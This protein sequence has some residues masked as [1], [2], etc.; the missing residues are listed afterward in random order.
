MKT[1]LSYRKHAVPSTEQSPLELEAPRDDVVHL[2]VQRNSA[3]TCLPALNKLLRYPKVQG[4]RV[5]QGYR[6]L[7]A[8]RV[9]KAGVECLCM[10]FC[11][12]H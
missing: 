5:A 10:S 6:F 9:R 4:N 7:G 11:L 2:W 3:D 12:E 1:V 8:S